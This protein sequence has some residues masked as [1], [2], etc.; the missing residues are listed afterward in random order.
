[1]AGFDLNC[2]CPKR[3]SVHAGMGAA[4]LTNPELL[5]KVCDQ[6]DD[7]ADGINS[8]YFSDL[9]QV[10]SKRGIASDMQNSVSGLV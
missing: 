5:E 3:F 8:V 10:G 7:L 6:E 4:L 2:G 9:D 1:M